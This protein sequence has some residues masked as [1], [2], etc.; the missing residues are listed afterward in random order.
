MSY[1]PFPTAPVSVVNRGE[2][3]AV[4]Q[5]KIDNYLKAVAAWNQRHKGSVAIRPSELSLAGFELAGGPRG[6]TSMRIEANLRS[7]VLAI[8]PMP[9]PG[10]E[11]RGQWFNHDAA[12][13]RKQ[14]KAWQQRQTVRES[15]Q[16]FALDL[17]KANKENFLGG[18]AN[19][20]Q[21]FDNMSKKLPSFLDKY[22]S[23]YNDEDL[24]QIKK[25]IN[26]A[27]ESLRF[28]ANVTTPAPKGKLFGFL[29][30]KVDQSVQQFIAVSLA[31][32]TAGVG[33]YLS[34]ASQAG[35][36]GGGAAGAA[37][38]EAVT[39]GA[40]FLVNTP[41]GAGLTGFVSGVPSSVVT[42]A[43]PASFV[44]NTPG[45]TTGLTQFTVTPVHNIQPT[46]VSQVGSWSQQQIA[47]VKQS[48]LANPV[49]SAIGGAGLGMTL[50]K[51]SESPDPFA[52][53]V[54][55]V[56]G[57]VGLPPLI[58]PPTPT[59]GMPSAFFSGG[60]GGG[61]GQGFGMGTTNI[62]STGILWILLAGGLL[63]L[64]LKLRK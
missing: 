31:A 32:I 14:L 52:S 35:T 20:N 6:S 5:S 44:V 15:A 46:L 36:V 55:T 8:D 26:A 56:A 60:G 59:P 29:P 25:G 16:R 37:G 43:A 10:Y 54:N 23:K 41:G 53:L 62:M 38:G 11:I 33:T 49:K 34:G 12:T 63:L 51:I 22:R 27:V 61:G 24:S 30:I 17:Y 50:K 58:Q 21:L 42:Y 3:V 9:Q 13:Y 28:T 2:T 47:D 7:N 45:S 57:A 64:A 48:I 40:P 4:P 19:L 39:V 18:G 1:D